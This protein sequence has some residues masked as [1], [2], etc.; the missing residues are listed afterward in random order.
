[1]DTM[2]TTRPGFYECPPTV[3]GVCEDDDYSEP[4]F[5]WE[6]A[7]RAA[8]AFRNEAV[9][10]EEAA[11]DAEFELALC[12]HAFAMAA[13]KDISKARKALEAA[14]AEVSKFR[15]LVNGR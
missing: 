5:D 13:D 7:D 4:A 1:M 10:R 14:R 15:K 3:W 11:K 8:E 9:A 2:S 12:L 6:A